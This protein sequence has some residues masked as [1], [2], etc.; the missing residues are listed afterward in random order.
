MQAHLFCHIFFRCRPTEFDIRQANLKQPQMIKPIYRQSRS[1][2]DDWN[3]RM[4]RRFAF[5]KC[6]RYMLSTQQKSIHIIIS[7]LHATS[8]HETLGTKTTDIDLVEE[9]FILQML[10]LHSIY[11]PDGFVNDR[12]GIL[13]E[14]R[15]G[16]S[17]RVKARARCA[18]IHSILDT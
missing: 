10:L 1:L 8:V 15:T 14:S 17:S 4:A 3:I 13:E 16:A 7:V 11:G 6:N 12:R 9:T 2:A 18:R 5:K